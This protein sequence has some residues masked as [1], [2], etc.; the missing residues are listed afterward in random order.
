[1]AH[2][3]RFTKAYL[4]LGVDGDLIVQDSSAFAGE[5]EQLS[6]LQVMMTV[7]AGR[8][9]GARALELREAESAR[10]LGGAPLAPCRPTD[11]LA[12]LCTQMQA[13]CASVQQILMGFY[14]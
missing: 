14:R 9:S 10:R 1:M 5:G 3:P 6:Y 12:P 13:R 4:Q 11:P 2:E 7:G 8:R